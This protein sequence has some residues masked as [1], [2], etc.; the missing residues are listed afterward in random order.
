MEEETASE[1]PPEPEPESAD[2]LAGTSDCHVV[3]PSTSSESASLAVLDAPAA[4]RVRPPSVAA[5]ESKFDFSD[6]GTLFAS[7]RQR[8]VMSPRNVPF[9]TKIDI[10]NHGWTPVKSYQYPV[11]VLNG[12]NR[13]FLPSWCDRFP[14]LDYSRCLDAAFCLPC[15]LFAA[16][17]QHLGQLYFLP[18]TNWRKASSEYCRRHEGQKAHQ[19]SML[20]YSEF[21]STPSGQQADVAMKLNSEHQQQAD[22]NTAR[23]RSVKSTVMFCGRQNIALRG[24]C[25]ESQSQRTRKDANPGN[26]LALMNLRAE[27][28]DK[29]ATGSFHQSRGSKEVTY[30]GNRIQNDIIQCCGDE[31]RAKIVHEVNA[32]PFFSV[33]ADEACDCSSQEQMPIVVRFVDSKSAIQEEFL[34][35]A[36]CNEGPSGRALAQVILAK[37]AD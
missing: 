33:L 7:D 17:S 18:F 29:C 11:C 21:L 19:T 30:C 4:K 34:G 1:Q 9:K 12:K 10:V 2:S 24:H 36:V 31:I 23:L 13:S 20:R 25:H 14:W 28:G 27:A 26:F 8:W 6:V 37:L 5:P 3:W 35:F 32:S 15:L 16:G 22:E